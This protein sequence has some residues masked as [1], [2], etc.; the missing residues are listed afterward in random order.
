MVKLC[1]KT[2]VDGSNQLGYDASLY[3]SYVWKVFLLMVLV[4]GLALFIGICTTGKIEE[5][6][7]EQEANESEKGCCRRCAECSL[8]FGLMPFV[9]FLLWIVFILALVLSYLFLIVYGIFMLMSYVCLNAVEGDVGVTIDD[10]LRTVLTNFFPQLDVD[11]GLPQFCSKANSA[12]SLFATSP[13]TLQGAGLWLYLGCLLAVVAQVLQLV[14]M[15]GEWQRIY[16]MM[17][18]SKATLEEVP[19][20]KTYGSINIKGTIIEP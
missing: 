14:A 1:A 11:K 10:S 16:T 20:E 15:Q 2:L 9:D 13:H 19:R 3:V 17:F 7:F 18:Q 8:G 4:N 6:L 5:S 12:G